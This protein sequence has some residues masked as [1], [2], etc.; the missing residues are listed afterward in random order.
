VLP[1]RLFDLIEQ[2]GTMNDCRGM[3]NFPPLG[4]RS[5]HTSATV[6]APMTVMLFAGM[7]LRRHS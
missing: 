6:L 5:V 3:A 1:F 7:S 4:F 2:T